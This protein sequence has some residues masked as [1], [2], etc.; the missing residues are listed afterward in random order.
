[1]PAGLPDGSGSAIIQSDGQP[2]VAIVNE[3]N[4]SLGICAIT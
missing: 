4:R 2:I 1:M 3:D